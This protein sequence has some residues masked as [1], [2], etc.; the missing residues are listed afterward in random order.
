[1][2]TSLQRTIQEKMD[3]ASRTINRRFEELGV[4]ISNFRSEVI[5]NYSGVDLAD[6]DDSLVDALDDI[7]TTSTLRRSARIAKINRASQ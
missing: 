5:E 6:P 3:A 7:E 1:M 2:T 4:I